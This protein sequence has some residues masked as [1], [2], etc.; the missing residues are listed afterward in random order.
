MSETQ[1][2]ESEKT[3]GREVTEAEKA[4][5]SILLKKR[6]FHIQITTANR[7]GYCE[8]GHK[9]IQKGERKYYLKLDNF[10]D[11]TWGNNGKMYAYVYCSRYCI[12]RLLREAE[13]R[14]K[15]DNPM[16]GYQQRGY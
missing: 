8:F 5:L 4:E 15:H 14:E 16:G 9:Q 2:A 11:N 12:L 13:E 7:R 10:W 6:G 1:M 3:L